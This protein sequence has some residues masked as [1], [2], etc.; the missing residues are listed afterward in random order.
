MARKAKSDP[1]NIAGRNCK[2][3]HHTFVGVDIVTSGNNEHT[4][5]HSLGRDLV[6][7]L[8]DQ[9]VGTGGERAGGIKSIPSNS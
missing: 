8:L 1:F 7:V 6:Q 5:W 9:I 2:P 3:L 4:A